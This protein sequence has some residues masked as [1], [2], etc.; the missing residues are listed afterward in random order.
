MSSLIYDESQVR[1]FYREVIAKVPAGPFDADFFCVAARKK[2]MSEA[3]REAT[4]LG[5]TCM[6]E[7]T[8]CREID[9]NIFIHKLQ[10]VDA[11]LDHLYSHNGAAIPRSCMVFYMNVN[12]TSMINALKD[13][14]MDVATME[15]ELYDVFLKNGSRENIG[16][17]LKRL[18]NI[19]L[20]AYQNPKN[21]V[22]RNWIDIDMDIDP[23]KISSENIKFAINYLLDC[24]H[25]E[26]EE[27]RGDN[28]YQI[29]KTHGGY[30]ILIDTDI[31]SKSNTFY[32]KELSAKED[33]KK[34]MLS[35][36]SF[37]D[38][39]EVEA[40]DK[41]G[42]DSIKEI[43]INQNGMV[44]IPGTLQGGVEVKLC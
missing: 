13:F 11:C 7:K 37:M 32:A 6:M 38:I 2:Y 15:A 31:I 25:I 4:R 30:H 3:E 12:H 9:E 28:L 42:L 21:V 41:V 24:Y 14:K 26:K 18:D 34:K 44:P 27:F 23:E 10:K 33:I 16:N 5:D 43:K 19:V 20:K 8:I 17:K 39:L 22:K 1:N 40:K 29:I 36:K 35:I